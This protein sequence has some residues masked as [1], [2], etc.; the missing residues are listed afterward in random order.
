MAAMKFG[1]GQ[2]LTR[3]EDDALLR[4]A[5]HYVADFSRQAAACTRW[6]CARRTRMRA[7]GFTDLA[8]ARAMPGVRLVLTADDIADLGPL[9]TPGIIPDVP[10]DYCRS[11]RSWRATSCAT[12]AM[13]LPLSSPIR[14]KT[15][16]MPPRR[17]TIDWQALPHVDRCHCRA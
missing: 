4:G 5:G 1:F 11:I 13:R 12:S 7:F 16:E 10:I 15:R 9:P 17:S 6:C 3:K 8:K 14:W 2:A